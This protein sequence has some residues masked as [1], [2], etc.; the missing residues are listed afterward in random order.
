MFVVGDVFVVVFI[1]SEYTLV[2][3]LVRQKRLSAVVIVVVVVVFVFVVI[4]VCICSMLLLLVC[5][6][7]LIELR[8][9]YKVGTL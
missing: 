3:V 6:L 5:M 8:T 1:V 7:L 4:V 2:Q 9:W